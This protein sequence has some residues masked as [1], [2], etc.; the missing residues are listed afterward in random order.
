MRTRPRK[1]LR[2]RPRATLRAYR[3][4]YEDSAGDEDRTTE[5]VFA[6]SKR[7]ARRC[8]QNYE[9]GYN[10]TISATRTRQFDRYRHRGTVPAAALLEDGWQYE[11]HSDV[12][13]DRVPCTEDDSCRGPAHQGPPVV[14]GDAV[15]C[16]AQCVREHE[17][18]QA[19]Y[20]GHTRGARFR[21]AELFEGV[22][23]T[24]RYVLRRPFYRELERPGV[25]A[26]VMVVFHPDHAPLFERDVIDFDLNLHTAGVEGAT[27]QTVRRLHAWLCETERLGT[28]HPLC[29]GLAPAF[30]ALKLPT[31]PCSLDASDPPPWLSPPG[32]T[33][34]ERLEHDGTDPDEAAG[35]LGWTRAAFD[36]FCAGTVPLT[37]ALAERLVPLF[38][39]TPEFWRRREAHYRAALAVQREQHAL[40]AAYDASAHPY[41]F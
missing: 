15:Y 20:A 25:I 17:H 12:C 13:G 39:G 3:I 19:T 8:A 38:G 26:R 37:D 40:D 31:A 4:S 6:R 27:A 10:A 16:N 18:A 5:I 22:N 36:A 1:T 28:A 30:K 35:M 2:P 14:L 33:V 7:G 24:A 9:P 41:V 11:C 32:E 29:E 34:R 23:A 21:V